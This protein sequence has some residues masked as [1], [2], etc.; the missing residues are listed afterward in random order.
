MDAPAPQPVVQTISQPMLL[1]QKI[2]GLEKQMRSGVD[3]FFWIAG[4][5]VVNTVV[6][7]FGG[8]ASFV[9]GLGATLVIDVLTKKLATDLAS[10]GG[11]IFQAIGIILDVLI[12]GLFVL[13]G[14]LGRKK[15]GTAVMFGMVL[16]VLDALIYLYLGDWMSVL[17]HGWML[18]ILWGGFQ[19]I[20]KLKKLEETA[21]P[22]DL[23]AARQL[24]SS[25]KA[26]PTASRVK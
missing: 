5:S 8:S 15:Y 19:A 21:N 14:I 4:L 3:T 12:M 16:Y 7:L 22:G 23:Y 20:G 1:A 2:V 6:Y 24:I 13:F 25:A 11:M 26:A 10:D 17:F 18:F 9:I